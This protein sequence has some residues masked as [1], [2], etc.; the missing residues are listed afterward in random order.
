MKCWMRVVALALAKLEIGFERT[1]LGVIAAF[2]IPR[3]IRLA[4]NVNNLG[5]ELVEIPSRFCEAGVVPTASA[6]AAIPIIPR[7]AK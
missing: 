1:I 5:I 3:E 6:A 4:V 7:T 2:T